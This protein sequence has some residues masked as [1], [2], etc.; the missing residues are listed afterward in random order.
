VN[1]TLAE[2]AGQAVADRIHRMLNRID[3]GADV[4]QYLVDNLGDPGAWTTR[5]S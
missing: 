5:A 4:R 3:W 2:E 1:W